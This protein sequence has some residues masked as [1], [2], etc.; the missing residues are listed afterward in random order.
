MSMELHNNIGMESFAS[1]GQG[2]FQMEQVSPR[3]P[4]SDCPR[5]VTNFPFLLQPPAD[6]SGASRPN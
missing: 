3:R 2:G 4:A 1:E 6:L 5:S